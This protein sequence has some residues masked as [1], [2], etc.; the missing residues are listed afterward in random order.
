[1]STVSFL[2]YIVEGGKIRTDPEKIQAVEGWPKPTSFKQL[3]LFLGFANF[4]RRFIR[5]YSRVAGPL[6][7][8]TS[9]TTGF[10][11]TPECDAAF[12]ELKRLFT[13]APVLIHP[14]SSRQFVVEVDAS[15]TKVGA[16]L[17]QRSEQDQQLHP[18]AFFSH[19]LTP[20]ENNYDVANREL[21]AVKLA[22]KEWRHWL[23]GA[24]LPFIVWTDHKN[25]AYIQSAK[26]LNCPSGSMGPVF[27]PLLIHPYLPPRVTEPQAGH[28]LASSLPKD[29]LPVQTPSCVV[30][31]VTWEFESLVKEAQRAQPNPSNCPANSLFVPTSVRS[32]V[33]QWAHTSSWCPPHIVY[34]QTAVLVTFHGS[35]HQGLCCCLYSM[36][37]RQ[38]LPPTSLWPASPAAST[39]SPLVALGLGFCYWTSILT[40]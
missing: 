4:Y 28:A 37:P 13:T 36:C 20:A 29:Q 25:L 32:K 26:R 2:G 8:L 33:L 6:T 22:L 38:V 11:W 21:L 35:R 15:N 10:S 34:T 27:R 31:A 7:R 16:V 19:L 5:D 24:E 39:N 9:P 30:A 18:C 14:D 17:S 40:K 1:M 12:S 23:E 3:Q